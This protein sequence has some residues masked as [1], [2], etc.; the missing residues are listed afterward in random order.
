[1]Y[2]NIKTLTVDPHGLV[3]NVENYNDAYSSTATVYMQDAKTPQ[4][5]PFTLTS[6]WTKILLPD[7]LPANTKGIIG[8]IRPYEHLL[9]V[10]KYLEIQASP[11]GTYVYPVLFLQSAGQ[12]PSTSVYWGT[13]TQFQTRTGT[14]N[15]SPV[16]YMRILGNAATTLWY[17]HLI[18]YQI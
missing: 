14:E 15:N 6:D 8:Y 2:D 17:F 12:P 3:L 16:I 11:D 5:S 13:G 4:G 18:A 10:A 1:M 7:I 9:D